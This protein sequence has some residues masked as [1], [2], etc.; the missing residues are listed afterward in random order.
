MAS[1]V[2]LRNK[3][4]SGMFWTAVQKYSGTAV[5]FVCGIILARLLTADDYGCL[6]MLTVFINISATF[7]DAGFSSALIQKRRPTEIDYSTIFYW[8]EGVA[9]GLYLILFVSAPAISRFY[10]IPL[11]SD[12]LRVQGIILILNAS[13]SVQDN[14]LRKQFKFRKLAII[15][16]IAS[17]VSTFVA[18]GMA[19]KGFGVWALVGQSISSSLVRNFAFWLTNK[20]KPLLAFSIGSFKELFSF[21]LYVFLG[22]L[23]NKI[24]NSLQS[25]LIGKVYDPSTLGYYSKAART[26]GY[27]SLSIS[28]ILLRVTYPLYS[29]VQH[30]KQAMISVI[31]R[32]STIVA[33]I[34][35]P[36]MMLLLL[37][38]KPMFVFLYSDRWLPSVPY[39]QILC[40]GGLA[41]CLQ[42][43]NYQPIAAIGKAKLLFKWTIIKRVIGMTAQIGG[44]LLWG[45]MGLLI[46]S[47]INNYFIYI[48]N[49]ALVSK[50]IGYKMKAQ[51]MDLFPI[52]LLTLVA[53][54]ISFLSGRLFASNMFLNASIMA[55]SFVIVYLGGSIIFRMEPFI[56]VR[57]TIIPSLLSRFKRPVCLINSDGNK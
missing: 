44:L 15:A 4:T 30:D 26:E 48:V 39:F 11:L 53:S 18:I 35:F 57:K 47:L 54:A 2:E 51:F 31:K 46:G 29:E 3:A 9:I 27:A 23:V 25:L 32:L 36:T 40:I 56:Y 5:Q 19:Y 42:G 20:W 49:S 34:S 8:N 6:G 41:M 37:I 14:R 22:N 52:F 50:Y 16:I 24:G 17:V 12:V 21:G 28:D 45:I 55:T 38:A 7:V 1:V 13:A 33:Y 43:V 10:G